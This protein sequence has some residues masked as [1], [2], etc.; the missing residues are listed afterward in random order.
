MLIEEVI[1]YVHAPT[2][3]NGEATLE[4]MERFSPIFILK[5]M[6]DCAV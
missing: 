3:K 4:E 6:G 1:A 5:S 2:S